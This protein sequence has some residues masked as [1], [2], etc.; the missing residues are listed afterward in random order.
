MGAGL[1]RPAGKKPRRVWENQKGQ[2][3]AEG[4]AR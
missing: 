4:E 1:H 2:R 3:Q